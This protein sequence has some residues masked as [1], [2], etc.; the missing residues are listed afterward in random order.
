MDQIQK[1]M[2]SDMSRR[3]VK[4]ELACLLREFLALAGEESTCDI[5]PKQRIMIQGLGLHKS[6]KDGFEAFV[7]VT[8]ATHIVLVS[9]ITWSASPPACEEPQ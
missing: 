3:H 2:A 7:T 5:R 8:F 4:A 9:K 1:P 6:H